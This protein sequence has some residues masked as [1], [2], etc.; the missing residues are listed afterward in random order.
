MRK[1]VLFIIS[2]VCISPFISA[3]V[4]NLSTGVANGTNAVMAAGTPDDTWTVTRPDGVT[5]TPTAIN[6][7]GA[8]GANSCGRWI[9][10]YPT[11]ANYP[12]PYAQTGVY[13]YKTTFTANQCNV[14]SAC[15]NLTALGGDDYV[16]EII[17]NG[18]SYPLAAS[19]FPLTTTTL[20]INPQNIVTGTNYL[21][22]KVVSVQTYTGLMICG[23]LNITNSAMVP[24]LTGSSTICSSSDLTFTGSDGVGY[25]FNHYWEILE[26]DMNNNVPV[27]GGFVWSTWVSGTP[28]IFTFPSNISVPC[29]KQYKIKLAVTNSC[30][31]WL[32]AP[33]LFVNYIC[34]PY[35]DAGPDQNLCPGQTITLGDPA[36]AKFQTY[37]W[38]PGTW[39]SSSTVKNPTVTIPAG[40]S[41]P[42]PLST[43][44]TVTTTSTLTGCSSTDVVTVKHATGPTPV[45][46]SETKGT[47][48]NYN[49]IITAISSCSSGVAY[50]WNLGGGTIVN[51]PTIN[52]V[53]AGTYT[54]T[55]T[56][57]CFT[58]TQT[59]TLVPC[60][61]PHNNF[62]PIY[63]NYAV[64]VNWS[65][66]YPQGGF[67]IYDNTLPDYAVPA[68]NANQMTLR[69]WSPNGTQLFNQSW[70]YTYNCSGAW[71]G[72]IFYNCAY[73]NSPL[74]GNFV[75]TWTLDLYNCGGDTDYG[76]RSYNGSFVVVD[77][78]TLEDGTKI[79]IVQ[80]VG[81]DHI[82]S[83]INWEEALSNA[84]TD[85]SNENI[86]IYPNPSTGKF[87]IELSEDITSDIEIFN[88]LGSKIYSL[89]R[90]NN[91]TR[92]EIDL[93]DQP[94]GIYM[95]NVTVNG[96]RITKKV[97]LQ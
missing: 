27:P 96:E 97:I 33:A 17:I 70:D 68:Y 49:N 46:F 18:N 6:P 23:T 37:S 42:C 81:A 88:M 41:E 69:V 24:T 71:N 15:F 30:T 89:K 74:P 92:Y 52:V 61:H 87:T 56:N 2:I 58:N 36:F 85:G 28:G 19:F 66:N 91:N 25:S 94:A 78:R 8:W 34:A 60:Y 45:T 84:D 11:N 7:H 50:S 22:I 75:Y 93:T 26:W 63:A 90:E 44:Y 76:H 35:F 38:S 47:G 57:A 10:P 39:L 65:G 59:H 67:R 31:P 32:E 51:S 16:S 3:Q 53:P 86:S 29:N 80:E 54:V 20:C 48:C 82:T 12:S 73:Q 1:I 79:P 9:S 64:T 5:V 13:E 4:I 21:T 55:T 77:V 43:V 72:E 95:V 62:P 83:R 14:S 40:F